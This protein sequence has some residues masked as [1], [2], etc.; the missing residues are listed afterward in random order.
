VSTKQISGGR[1]D[2]TSG[3]LESVISLRNDPS[4]DDSE[5]NTGTVVCCRPRAKDASDLLASYKRVCMCAVD[6]CIML[7]VSQWEQFHTIVGGHK[8]RERRR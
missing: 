6:L 7:H 3:S 1:G 2:T 8:E 5:H 4:N